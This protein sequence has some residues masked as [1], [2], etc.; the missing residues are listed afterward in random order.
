MIQNKAYLQFSD[1]NLTL[2]LFFEVYYDVSIINHPL[3][4]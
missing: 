1:H 4:L 2:H 3:H